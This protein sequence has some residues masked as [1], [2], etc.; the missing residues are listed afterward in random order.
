MSCHDEVLKIGK[1]LEKMISSKSTDD[2]LGLD[3]LKAL[4]KLPMTLDVLTKTRVGM[5]VNNFR[6]TC[7]KEEVVTL[8]KA[9]IKSWKK[10]LPE[11]QSSSGSQSKS[12]LSRSSS[13]VSSSKDE[14]SHDSQQNDN[15]SQKSDSSH[16]SD[17]PRPPTN[18]PSKVA[19][20]TDTVRLKCRELLMAALQLGGPVEGAAEPAL[21]AAAIED[22]IF[23]EFK[24]TE[25][26]YK[27]RVRSRIANL[28]DSK[29][30]RLREDVLLGYI[31]PERMAV[32]TAEEM[33]SKEMKEL[34][35]KLTK[36]AIDDHQLATQSGT[37]SDLFKCSKCNKRDTTYNQVQ[38]RS[39]DE[40]MTT[41]VLC[42]ACGNRWKF[43]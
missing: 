28:K 2:S 31:S 25:I 13:S 6:K 34:R 10:L 37:Q 18:F 22:C 40:P 9:L 21:V 15:T 5:T 7:K 30:P 29:N 32:M 1:K 19:G 41:F 11:S 24:N 35:A 23:Q 14:D 36:E 38:T 43:C 39:A 4:Q 8:A 33:A 26:K 20:T 27:N 42:N 3:L 17:S 12:A 16:G